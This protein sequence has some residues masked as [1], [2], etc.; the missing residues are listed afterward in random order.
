MSAPTRSDA[1]SQAAEAPLPE[2]PP[3]YEDYQ[4]PRTT[5]EGGITMLLSGV[6]AAAGLGALLLALF[7]KLADVKT[8]GQIGNLLLGAVA[9]FLLALYILV[10]E[11]TVR[12]IARADE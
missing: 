12:M 1:P 2:R 6:V 3:T 4:P 5:A 7:S 10:W 9:L 11:V 8:F